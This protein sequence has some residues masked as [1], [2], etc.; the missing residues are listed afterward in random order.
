M[1]LV[2]IVL[3]IGGIYSIVTAK[4]PAFLVGGGFY[5]VDRWIARTIGFLLLIPLIVAT[6]GGGIS[7]PLFGGN[8]AENLS[9][10]IA[11]LFVVGVLVLVLTRVVGRQIEPASDMEAIIAKKTQRALTYAIMSPV[12]FVTFPLAL[13]IANQALKLIDQYGVG[14]QYRGRAK[15]SRIIGIVATLLS[16]MGW[17]VLSFYG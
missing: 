12:I 15:A 1:L 17:L 11:T 3:F 16:I 9:L 8:P 13:I 10:E 2:E 6:I 14:E 7:N 5:Q 4:V